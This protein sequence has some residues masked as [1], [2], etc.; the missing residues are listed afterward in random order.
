MFAGASPT[1][2]RSGQENSGTDRMVCPAV[3]CS[4]VRSP[5]PTR[6]E[7]GL[8]SLQGDGGAG[9]LQGS[10]RLLRSVLGNLLQDRFRGGV[11]EVLGLLQTEAREGAHLLDDLDLLLAGRLEDDVELVLL[12][13]LG[14]CRR[15][16]A[17]SRNS[18]RGRSGDTEGVLEQ[19]HELRELDEC[20]FLERLD[21]SFS[22]ELCH[23]G[24][25]FLVVRTHAVS[26]VGGGSKRRDRVASAPVATRGD[27]FGGVRR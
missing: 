23:G 8:G 9:A 18:N 16:A 25:P 27:V 13:D 3:G 20:H 22:A 2:R 17:G 10:L 14:G 5:G 11:D 19:R 15:P 12:L 21:E 1:R 26:G 24:S 6:S 7:R 4:A